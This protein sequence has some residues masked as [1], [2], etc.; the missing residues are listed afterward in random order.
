MDAPRKFGRYT[1]VSLL[2]EGAMGRVFLAHDPFLDRNVALKAISID[3]LVDKNMRDDYLK[4]FSF[5][6]K[7]S[8]KLNHPSIVAVYDAGQENGVP[9]I[10]FEFVD[11]ESLESLI[12]RK[13]RLP[14]RRALAFA[15]DI[16]SALQHAHGWSIVHRDV[17]PANIIIESSTG[18]AKL[19]DFGIVKAPWAV[20]PR[21][22]NTVGSP[23]YMSPEQFDGTDLDE[24]ADLFCLGVVIYQ[25]IAGVHP[26]LRDTMA[27]TMFATCNNEYTPL[28]DIVEGVPPAL[29]WAVRRC[30]NADRDKRLHSAT[31]LI[32]ML[33]KATDLRRGMK[34]LSSS[35][36]GTTTVHSAA[37]AASMEK[38]LGTMQR[39]ATTAPPSG[40]IAQSLDR[41][42]SF[43]LRF[44][45]SAMSG[46]SRDITNI[47]NAFLLKIRLLHSHK[48]NTISPLIITAAALFMVIIIVTAAI[49]L[50]SGNV[51]D[52]PP[53]NSPQG[54]LI[55]QCSAAL[56]ENNRAAA[57]NAVDGLSAINPRHPLADV[58]LARVNIRNGMFDAAKAGLLGV[59]SVKS[60]GGII[61][62]QLPAILDDISRPLRTGPA[63]PQAVELVRYVLLA[64]SHPIVQSWTKSPS[65]WLRW[66]AVDIL[67]KS[68]SAVDMTSV[69]IQDLSCRDKL[70]TR[71]QAVARLGTSDDR[72]ALDA[73]REAAGRGAA[74]PL[75]AQEAKR[76]LDEKGR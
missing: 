75:V 21:G 23:G 65:Y 9:W 51:S 25:M 33:N 44:F 17:K 73:L 52:L 76:V 22:E 2:G 41:S 50:T 15:H 56:Q 18:I 48:T 34:D 49:V 7:A 3:A 64:G 20:M 47:A 30:C 19:A 54:R 29:D 39:Q 13:G 70:Q 1:A 62:K 67:Q 24:R 36:Y 6:A 66:N 63:P 68:N 69:F 4:R 35:P 5:E 31:E 37:D 53:E 27:A 55:L 74:D 40:I 43:S 60:G 12:N 28:R 8:A 61:K 26:F 38:I 10:A 16:A 72:R 59:E 42:I 45:S 57:M 71:L 14:I 11:G 32:E 46:F 58:L